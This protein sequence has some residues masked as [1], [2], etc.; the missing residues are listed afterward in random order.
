MATCRSVGQYLVGVMHELVKVDS[1]PCTAKETSQLISQHE[2]FIKATF[3]HPQLV[4]LQ[5][6][7][8]AIMKA[9][10][11]EDFVLGNSEDYR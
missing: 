8:E 2:N 3:D 1:M 6:D 7:G 10:R 9:L 4:S 11:K 5:N